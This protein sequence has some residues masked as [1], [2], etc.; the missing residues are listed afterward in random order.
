VGDDQ[1]VIRD[2]IYL[3]GTLMDIGTTAEWP[4]PRFTFFCGIDGDRSTG[5]GIGQEVVSYPTAR[6]AMLAAAL[7]TRS[8]EHRDG[9]NRLEGLVDKAL[10]P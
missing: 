4:D 6:Q 5:C 2:G 3:C 1:D 7:H 9:L 10:K 8:I